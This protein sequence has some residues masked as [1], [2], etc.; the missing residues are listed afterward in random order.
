M[1]Y[2]GPAGTPIQCEKSET[3][4]GIKCAKELGLNAYEVEFVRGVKMKEELAL[5]IKEENQKLKLRISSHAPYYINLATMEKD[6]EKRSIY[7]ILSSA[8]TTYLMGGDITVIHPGYYQKLSKEKAY[9]LVRERLK[10]IAERIREEKIKVKLGIE[11]MGKLS[12]FGKL[13]EVIKLSQEI[14]EV[15]PVI[16]FAHLRALKVSSFKEEEDYIKIFETIEE[17][18]EGYAKNFHVHFSEIEFGEK[19]EK[20]HLE[21]GTNYE[22]DYRAFIRACVNNGF[23]GVVICESP[24][25]DI[26]AQKMKE[27]YEEIT[28]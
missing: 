1:L 9:E 14:D 22:P 11:T 28:K 25:I 13:E 6:K 20:R 21:L 4:E 19:G 18:V 3:L 17:E 15:Y 26:D 23:S 24:K 7:H 5:K 10:K 27:Y 12:T 2:F 8:K 16:D